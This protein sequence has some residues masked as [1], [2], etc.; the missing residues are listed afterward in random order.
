MGYD[1]VHCS[2]A[3]LR[4]TEQSMSESWKEGWD[5]VEAFLRP[6]GGPRMFP[7]AVVPGLG[8]KPVGA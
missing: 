6:R 7:N 8:I 1:M 3:C 2:D 4:K 5:S